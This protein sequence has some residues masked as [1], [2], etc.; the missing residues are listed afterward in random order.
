LREQPIT[1]S[2]VAS[3]SFGYAD[4]DEETVGMVKREVSPNSDVL[5]IQ[6]WGCTPISISTGD[7]KEIVR[8]VDKTEGMTL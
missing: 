3:K 6:I 4:Y 5:T 8:F 7:F 1:V 2:K